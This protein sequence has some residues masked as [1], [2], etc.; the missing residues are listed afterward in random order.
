MLPVL[1]TSQGFHCNFLPVMCL[2]HVTIH[3]FNLHTAIFLPHYKRVLF[4]HLLVFNLWIKPVMAT[5]LQ[6][7]S[8]NKLEHLPPKFSIITLDQLS[9]VFGLCKWTGL[10]SRPSSNSPSKPGP[11]R[12]KRWEPRQYQHSIPQLDCQN[13]PTGGYF[14]PRGAIGQCLLA[15][16]V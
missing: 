12:W 14:E 6:W 16:D 4:S 10:L 8:N 9:V 3:G 5:P 7:F 1:H 11:V 15:F 13:P 2:R